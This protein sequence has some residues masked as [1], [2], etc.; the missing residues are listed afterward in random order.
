VQVNGC[1]RIGQGVSKATPCSTAT[2]WSAVPWA[3]RVGG[4]SGV[5]Q[6][7]GLTSASAS[8]LGDGPSSQVTSLGSPV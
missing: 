2:I 1:A 8:A 3:I 6:V 5:T 7:I 4:A